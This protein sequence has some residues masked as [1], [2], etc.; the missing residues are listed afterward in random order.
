MTDTRL[1]SPLLAYPVGSIYMSVNSTSPA[2]LFGG[3]WER[4]TGRFLL[5]A[6]DNGANG[7]N[8]NASISPGYTGGEATHTL[9]PGETATKNHTHTIN[10]GHTQVA[11]NHGVV[12]SGSNQVSGSGFQYIYSSSKTMQNYYGANDM[13]KNATP[14][15][16]DYNGSSGGQTEANG[17]AHNNMPPY[18]AVYVWK[19]TA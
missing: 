7:G 2:T 18:L 10:H 9:T 17:S 4:I 13:V 6:T 14:T 16:N 11:H 1:N 15:I 19:R 5:A 3:T 8:S 12:I